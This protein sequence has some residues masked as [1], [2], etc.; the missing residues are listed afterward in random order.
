[1]FSASPLLRRSESWKLFQIEHEKRW[2]IRSKEKYGGLYILYTDNVIVNM[3]L[4]YVLDEVLEPVFEQPISAAQGS[5]RG[6]L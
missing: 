2:C 1:M 5:S 3:S 6:Y 4:L